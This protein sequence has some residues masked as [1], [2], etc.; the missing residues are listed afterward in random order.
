[1]VVCRVIAVHV[2]NRLSHHFGVESVLDVTPGGTPPSTVSYLNVFPYLD[3][4]VSGFD[5]IPPKK[6]AATAAGAV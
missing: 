2:E 4:P 6:G 3:H 5:V 1:M